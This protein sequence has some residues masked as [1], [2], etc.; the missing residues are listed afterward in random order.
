M[1]RLK[2]GPRRTR[3]NN[4]DQSIWRRF[5][6]NF[7]ISLLGSVLSLVIKLGQTVLLT[8]ALQIADYGRVLIVLNLF[9]FLNSFIGLRVSDVVFRFF[10]PLKEREDAASLQGLLLLCLGIS[11]ATGLLICCGVFILAPW[12]AG[13]LYQ[14]PELASLFYIYGCTVLISSF[15]DVF[16]PILRLHDRFTAVVL[17]QVLGNLTTLVILIVYL[18][19]ADGYNL[20]II[21]AAF[22]IGM[23]VQT[24]PPLVQTLRLLKPSLAGVNAKRSA[25]A[26]VKYRSE[27]IRC[28]FNSNVSGY[29]KFAISPGDIFLLGLF[30]SPEQ[31]ALY[32]LAKQITAPLAL[33]QTNLQTAITPEIISLVA[34]RRLEQLKRLISRYVGSAIVLGGLLTVSALLCGRFLIGWLSRPEYLTALPVFYALLIVIWGMTVLAVFR[35]LALSLD[36]LKW[37][38]LAQLTSS[39]ILFLFI[40]AG[41]LNALTMACVQLGGVLGGRALFYIPVWMRVR[42]LEAD[43]SQNDGP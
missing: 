42:A 6:R 26:L 8:R 15:S 10:Q 24:V 12:L 9:V 27:L 11:L 19:T 36:L 33:L 21:I 23:L 18:A 13:R 1:P 5:K 7:S 37:H 17:P 30:S 34:R 43:F 16:E 31:V 14:N 38:N 4:E 28:L 25:R 29:L 32:G 35:P 39:I 20:A 3:M 41:E 22:A 2:R 40:L